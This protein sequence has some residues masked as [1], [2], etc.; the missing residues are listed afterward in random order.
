MFPCFN[1]FFVS[2]NLSN[3]ISCVYA[4]EQYNYTVENILLC[5]RGLSV[6]TVV[7]RVLSGVLV[8]MNSL[9]IGSPHTRFSI[10]P[11]LLQSSGLNPILIAQFSLFVGIL[12]MWTIFWGK[13]LK[14]LVKLPMIAGQIIGGILLGPSLLNIAQL[15]IF[16]QPLTLMDYMTGQSY[17][18]LTSDLF[19]FFILLIS[20]SLTVSYLLWIA[21]HETDLKDIWCIGGT[22]VTAGFFGAFF[23]IIMT[24]GAL[25]LGVGGGD[26][27]FVQTIGLG[28]IFSATSVSIPV[29]T[30]FAYNKMHL[31]SSK[32]TL[33]A[34]V[35]DDILAV[36]LLS[37]FSFAL[38]AGMF[39]TNNTITLH[40]D[41]SGSIIGMLV[42]MFLSFIIILGAG[43]YIIPPLIRWLRKEH[44]SHLIAP[45]ANS[46]MLFYFAFSELFGGM[47]G[48]TGAYFAGLF[49]RMGDTQHRAERVISP[50]V[51]AIL[52]PLFLGSIGL[53]INIRILKWVDWVTVFILL[54]VAIISKLLGCWIT[55]FFG[56]IF[57]QDKSKWTMLES[58]LFG[59]SMVAR[60]E[61]G[62]V[63]ATILY[64]SRIVTS[65]QYVIAVVVILLTTIA[66]PIMLAIG[67]AQ[68]KMLAV[69]EDHKLNIGLFKVIG[70]R[71]MFNIIMG[72]IE[73]SGQLKTSIQM[74]EGRRIINIEGKRVKIIL[75]PD[76]GIIFEGNRENVQEILRIVHES[77]ADDVGRLSIF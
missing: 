45:V 17:T 56:N 1:C 47:A 70:T 30:L 27:N 14:V 60:G 29:A 52:L 39:H 63:I 23:P 74:S 64:A 42:Y 21:G 31:R 61:V 43:Y 46:I 26:W 8:M 66:S 4:K 59:S 57:A 5:K 18:L 65:D 62:L 12:L 15:S 55:N 11:G 32:A 16:A 44:Y 38:Q 76:E 67:F 6:N 40:I 13:I 35:V 75:C 69:K 19:V 71:R 51:N 22:A 34:A 58:Y 50:F 25:F 72:S 33:G 54:F 41:S 49:H 36:I 28:L 37:V 3:Y 2:N 10:P 68:L 7:F 20:S 73:A 53:Q 48:I 9:I 24:V 77:I